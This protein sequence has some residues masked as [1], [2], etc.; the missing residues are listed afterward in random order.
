MNIQQ[1]ISQAYSQTR[2][3]AQM[4]DLVFPEDKYP[5]ARRSSADGGPPGCVMAF[6]AA[7]RRMGGRRDGARVWL[8]HMHQPPAMLGR[9]DLVRRTCP[10]CSGTGKDPKKRT[11]PCPTCSGEKKALFCRQCGGLYGEDCV[12][13]M[14]DE[15]YCSKPATK[16][17]VVK[18][19][20]LHPVK[21]GGDNGQKYSR[22]IDAGITYQWIGIGWMNEGR[23]TAEDKT[24][25]PTIVDG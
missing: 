22:V 5:K 3:Y 13:T 18:R 14:L 11:R 15:T 8:P 19:S 12:D 25:L 7:L 21:M 16:L 20:E 9:M 10:H 2:N 17:N 23:A 6:G 24:K 1:R 4:M